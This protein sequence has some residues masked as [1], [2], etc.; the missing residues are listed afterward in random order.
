MFLQPTVYGP[1][2]VVA[3][4]ACLAVAAGGCCAVRLPVTSAAEATRAN[5]DTMTK[6]RIRMEVLMSFFSCFFAYLNG[7]DCGT[8]H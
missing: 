7:Y 6:T 4:F 5:N 1:Q 3:Y 2:P 8:I